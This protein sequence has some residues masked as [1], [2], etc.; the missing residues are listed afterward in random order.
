MAERLRNTDIWGI[1]QSYKDGRDEWHQVSEETKQQ[2]R[3][4]MRTDGATKPADPG[5]KIV[6]QGQTIPLQNETELKLEDGT[7]LRVARQLP[8]D[9]PLGYHTLRDVRSEAETSL[10]VVPEKCFLEENFRIWGWALQL[11]SLRSR[12]SWGMG[13]FADL[14]AFSKFVVDDLG[15]GIIMT[16]PMNAAAPGTPQQASPYSPT[17]RIYRNLL[18]LRVHDVP[19][20]R[21]VAADFEVFEKQGAALNAL[22]VIDRDAIYKLKSDALGR[23]WQSTREHVDLAAYEKQEGPQLD[24]FAAYCVLAERYG[25]NWREWPSQFRRPDSP[26]SQQLLRDDSDRIRFYKWVQFS[27][28]QQFAKVCTRPVLMQDLPIGVDPAGADAWAWQDIFAQNVSV[29]APPDIFN[30]QGQDW[31]LQPFIP[32]KLRMANYEPF[33]KTVRANMRHSTGLRIDHV[34]G[35]FRLFWIPV[36]AEKRSGTYVRYRYEELLALLALESVRAGAFVVGEDLGTVEDGVREALAARGVLSY[37][38]MWF[39]EEPPA[40]YQT[41]ALAAIT[42]HDLPTVAGLWTGADLAEQQALGLKPNVEGT[43]ESR[44]NLKR[45][46]GLTE[47]SPI[48]DVVLHA[49]KALA[50]APS[51]VIIAALEDALKLEKR[52]N[53]PGTLPDKRANWSMPLPESLDE[54]QHDPYMRKLAEVIRTTRATGEPAENASIAGASNMNKK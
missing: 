43:K 27:L 52:P 24:R 32:Y 48:E 15:A 47:E 3:K 18:Y 20:A 13:D 49:Y 31:G 30:T 17:S 40:T 51:V 37:K 6:D 33:I 14:R 34:M 19:G 5:L 22:P 2:L 23:I 42:T 39:E 54:L 44:E 35:L 11:Y 10:I 25:Q 1:D 38:V 21:E 4:A 16:N 45:I 29:G 41:N 12:H 7:L 53:L 26:A 8:T 46:A 28:E 50:K 9:L 36:G